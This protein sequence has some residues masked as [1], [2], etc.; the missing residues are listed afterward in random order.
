MT[1]ITINNFRYLLE[2][3]EKNL[4]QIEALLEQMSILLKS[5]YVSSG[6]MSKMC[7]NWINQLEHRK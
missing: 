6:V 5:T 2:D 4:R 1:D 7:E 3:L